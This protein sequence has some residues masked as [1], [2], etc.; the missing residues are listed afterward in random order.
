MN[1]VIFS[2]NPIFPNLVTG[3][4]SKHLYRVA[5]HLGA[6][7][8]HVNLLCAQPQEE[9]P[10][11]MWSENV[12]VTPSLPFHLPFPQPY[13]VS[14]AD[15]TLIARRVYEAL[16]SA[17]RFYIHDGEFL[18]PDVYESIPT[19]TSFRDN[20]YPESVL[21]SF[22]G[23]ADDIIC[24]SNYS[25]SVI[26]HSVGQ[27]YPEIKDR[28]HKVINGLD[29]SNFSPK[30][31]SPLAK[32]L[33]IDRESTYI[34]L[35]PHR[36]E[37]GKGLKETILVLNRLVHH[38]GIK[39]IK[40]LVP[41]W[42]DSMVSAGESSYA[43][44]MRQMMQERDLERYFVTFPW[45]SIKRM[46][47]L[48][49]LGDVTLCL[50]LFVEAFGNVAYESLACGTPSVVA[51]VG[52]HRTQMPDDLIDKIEPGNI[53]MAAE[54]IVEILQGR[55][56]RHSEIRAYINSNMNVE[57][58]KEGYA[59]AITNSKK[60]KPMQFSPVKLTENQS[61]L[62]APWC[63]VEGDQIFHD[64]KSTFTRDEQLSQLL[65]SGDS[66]TFS[67][68]TRVGVSESRWQAW[69]DQTWLVPKL[70]EI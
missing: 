63:Y 61:F 15:L 46:A 18:L 69:M 19:T 23:R 70:E 8:H 6:L 9:L 37:P 36:P 28:I 65:L 51:K 2:I 55:P 26:A 41:N 44:Q 3:G 48:Y 66:I 16:Q 22:I 35:H 12:W 25:C 10:H 47:E 21:G 33:G 49:S 54:R 38:H 64:Y 31:P 20:I 29:L 40:V 57:K 52:V 43:N 30:D 60:R 39:N 27:F 42:I 24:I 67:D 11:F 13:A 53:D 34:L 59:Q 17:D 50:G 4:A 62:L 7:G 32:E 14:G 45:L 1:I 68:A 5:N 56:S 58:Q